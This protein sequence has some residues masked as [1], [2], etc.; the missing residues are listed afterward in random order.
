M[1][2]TSQHWGSFSDQTGNFRMRPTGPAIMTEPADLDL[3]RPHVLHQDSGF[4]FKGRDEQHLR[5]PT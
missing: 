5:V 4:R 2:F 3:K 1:A